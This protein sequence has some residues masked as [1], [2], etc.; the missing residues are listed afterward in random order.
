MENVIIYLPHWSNQTLVFYLLLGIF[1]I[2]SIRYNHGTITKFGLFDGLWFLVWTIAPTFRII[3]HTGIGGSDAYGYIKYF[4]ICNNE[5]LNSAYSHTADDWGF[6]IINQLLNGICGDYH[7]FLFAVYAFE[8]YS[9]ICFCKVFCTRET[10]VLPFFLTPY[11]FIRSF[12][13]IRSNLAIAFFL[14]A[15]VLLAKRKNIMTIVVAVFSVL[16]HKMLIVYLPFLFLFLK[17]EKIRLSRKVILISFGISAGL[18]VVLKQVILRYVHT[19]NMDGAYASYIRDSSSFLQTWGI[20]FEQLMLGVAMVC[21]LGK[22]YSYCNNGVEEE[23][24]INRLL[25]MGCIYDVLLVPICGAMGI[26]RGYEIMYLPRIV[27]WSIMISVCQQYM[28]EGT[29]NL[30]NALVF[31]VL[32]A[33]LIFRYYATWQSSSLMPFIFEFFQF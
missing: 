1:P 5:H 3:Q 15:M 13:T 18:I 2:L 31:M 17:F 23:N 16:V 11:L 28:S 29:K 21:M 10:N 33:W 8:V 7:F 30:V 14:L 26:W 22:L 20:A 12:V 19:L 27:M 25:L 32:L 24:H 4:E 6:K 9:F